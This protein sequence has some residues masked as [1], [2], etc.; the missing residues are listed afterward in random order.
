MVAKAPD[1]TGQRFGRLTVL[2]KDPVR[3]NNCV[4]WMCR[5]DCGGEK[6]VA[7]HALRSGRTQ[8]C[9]CLW[10]ASRTK[11]GAGA[12][13]APVDRLY[14]VWW[15]MNSR[16]RNERH[17]SF[18]NYGG[19]GIYVCARWRDYAAF[20]SDMAPSYQSGLTIERVDNDGPYSPENCRWATYA[21]QARNKR[22]RTKLV[23]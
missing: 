3:K 21:E 20:R 14:R 23:R 1:L 17:R 6:P 7:T 13:G 10:W 2:R 16:C 15:G 8:S 4:L 9:G 12:R 19:R 18:K 22:P 5:C 11:H